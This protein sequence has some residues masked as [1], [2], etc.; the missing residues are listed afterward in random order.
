M[1]VCGMQIK[2]AISFYHENKT[3]EEIDARNFAV[4]MVVGGCCWAIA[5][6]CLGCIIWLNIIVY[7]IPTEEI[8]E[9]SS[10]TENFVYYSDKQGW[11]FCGFFTILAVGMLATW[12][13]VLFEV[14]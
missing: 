2:D 3:I 4:K 14:K 6:S 11:V 12:V 9:G 10:Y 1:V 13:F 7:N 8:S 5:I